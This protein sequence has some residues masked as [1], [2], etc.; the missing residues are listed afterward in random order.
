MVTGI[1]M[2]TMFIGFSL[3]APLY[4]AANNR[5]CLYGP[6]SMRNTFSMSVLYRKKQTVASLLGERDARIVRNSQTIIFFL[7][8]PL[9]TSWRL[10]EL[11]NNSTVRI[12][13]RMLNTQWWHLKCLV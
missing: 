13:V 3:C 8:I 2:I 12:R 11:R 4:Q 7:E 10:Q 5:F 1:R 9:N 6:Q